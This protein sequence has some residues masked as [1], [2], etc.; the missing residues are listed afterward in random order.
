MSTLADSSRDG[1]WPEYN[2]DALAVW[3]RIAEC[4]D[5]YMGDRGNDFHNVLVRPVAMQLLQPVRGRKILELG[6]GAGLYTRDLLRAGADI[7]AT[8]GAEAFVNIAARRNPD[9]EVLRL[10]VTSEEDWTGLHRRHKQF[11]A[12]VCN[13]LFMDV[14]VVDLMCR[15]VASLLR[16]GGVWV[17]SQQHPCFVTPDAELV[18]AQGI[19]G[20]RNSVMVH[21]YLNVEPYKAGGIRTQPETHYY[22]HRPL[23][24]IVGHLVAAGLVVNGLVEPSFPPTAEP[25]QPLSYGSMPDIP[26]VLFL[27]ALK[28]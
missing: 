2:R 24:T 21:R 3:E 26:P 13:M 19:A 22:F 14:A 17:I 1:Q 23:Q 11:D 18:A 10:D 7:V 6:C 16:S 25:F 20:Q 15:Q 27:R 4:W 5:A 28:P 12:V 9:C 8:D